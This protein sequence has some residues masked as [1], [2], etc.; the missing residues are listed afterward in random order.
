MKQNLRTF[1]K[2]LD[3]NCPEQIAHVNKEVDPKYEI[4]S[5]V[6]AHQDEGQRGRHVANYPLIHVERGNVKGYPEWEVVTNVLATRQRL[7]EALQTT[8]D[9]LLWKYL[10]RREKLLDYN[11]VSKGAVQE[12]VKTG[13]DVD[14]ST[15][16]LL[17]HTPEEPAPFIDAEVFVV[18]D[19]E[20]ERHNCG[21]YRMM[22]KD[23]NKT[24]LFLA[25]GTH[26]YSILSQAEARD[27]PLPFAAYVGHHPAAI[28]GCQVHTVEDEYKAIGGVLGEPMD[29][30]KCKTNDLLV[31]ADAELVVEGVIQPHVREKEGPFCEFTYLL[32][33][34]RESPVAEVTAITHRKD[35]IYYDVYN[36]Y[37][38]H[39][40]HGALPM[41][42]DV[43]RKA[44]DAVSQVMD[45][46]L[47]PECSKFVAIVQVRNEYPGVG[48]QAAI[49]AS[50]GKYFMKYV[51]VVDEEQNPYDM[52]DIWWA[53]AM[54]CRPDRD[55]NFIKDA[56]IECLDPIGTDGRGWP[57]TGGGVD[58]RVFIDAT[59][60]LDVDYPPHCEPPKEIWENMDLDEYI[61]GRK[62]S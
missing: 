57:Y 17:T 26:A 6:R 12:V 10:E 9:N 50:S 60:P 44:K 39:L 29:L 45:V 58:T 62:S 49:A 34:E 55:I 4:A 40:M 38:D 5:L 32:G 35:P 48:K 56:Y 53:M 18:W 43:Y 27:E 52:H 37:I 7:A 11:V 19:S 47:P 25:R 20:N 1:L 23:K 28:M 36:P 16:P 13:K 31:P 24:G 33:K 2:Q 15:L 59:K 22:K 8:P 42:T 41:E 61:R 51:V 54:K 30:V 3:D 46:H 21:I 14:L